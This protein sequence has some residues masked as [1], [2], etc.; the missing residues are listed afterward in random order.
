[1]AIKRKN[2]NMQPQTN[3][4][5]IRFIFRK[6]PETRY[7]RGLFFW[8]YLEEYYGAKFYITKE[9]FIK[10]FHQEFWGLERA[11]RDVLKEEEFKLP[12]DKDQKRYE[13]ASLFR[14][15]FKNGDREVIPQ[16]PPKAP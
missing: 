12:A 11:V 2:E 13:K 9:E 6:Y 14:E 1:L 4:D 16:S 15:Q 10:F 8:R 3:K 5:K 7:S